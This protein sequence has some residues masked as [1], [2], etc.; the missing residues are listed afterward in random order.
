MLNKPA[1][2]DGLL[3]IKVSHKQHSVTKFIAAILMNL[4]TPKSE[5][6]HELLFNTPTTDSY[7]IAKHCEFLTN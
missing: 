3:N 4:V 2:E 6:E 5:A 7:T 1:L